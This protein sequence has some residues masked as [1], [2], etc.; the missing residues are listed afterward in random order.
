MVS[1]LWTN[2]W[3][4][5]ALT[6]TISNLQAQ[7]NNLS[8]QLGNYDTST[9]EWSQ[10]IDALNNRI[11]VYQ[12]AINEYKWLMWQIQARAA[13][14]RRGSGIKQQAKQWYIT[15]LSTKRGMTHAEAM[16]DMA[17]IEATGRAERAEIRWQEQEN[18]ASAHGGLANL[19]STMWAEQADID[20]A[21]KVAPS[22]SKWS[23]LSSALNKY[24]VATDNKTDDDVNGVIGT[25]TTSDGTTTDWT[26]TSSGG[27]TVKKK[28]IWKFWNTL[29]GSII[30]YTFNPSI[31]WQWIAMNNIF[32]KITWK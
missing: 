32:K 4:V 15:W 21:N 30:N 16:K 26:T 25:P 7:I 1:Q 20:A 2:D 17:D 11:A 3:G 23:S 27:T 22:S 24:P 29:G 9:L 6:Q 14:D 13:E 18:L 5:E 10:S 28:P 31:I 8:W 12:K 19:Y